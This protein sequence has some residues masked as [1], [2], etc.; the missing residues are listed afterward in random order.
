RPIDHA[1]MAGMWELPEATVRN[2]T[3]ELLF[4]LKHSITVTNFKVKVVS[5]SDVSRG[6]GRWVK[7]S[8]LNSI[9]LTGLA[10]KVLSR[11]EVI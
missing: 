8:R 7:V 2:D 6:N 5:S 10:R 9:P 1:L 11:A 3:D 4:T